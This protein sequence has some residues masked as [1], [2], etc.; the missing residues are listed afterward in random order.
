MIEFARVGSGV[1][2]DGV[3]GAPGGNGEGDEVQGV[4]GDLMA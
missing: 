3:L 2:G 1:D 4:E